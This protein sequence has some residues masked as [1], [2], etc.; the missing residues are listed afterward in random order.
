MLLSI[1]MKEKQERKLK[2]KLML[3]ILQEKREKIG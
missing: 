3:G 2:K 1:L